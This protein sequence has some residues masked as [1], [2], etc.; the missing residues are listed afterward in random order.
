ML[1]RDVNQID[2]TPENGNA[3]TPFSAHFAAPNLIL[4]GDP[5]A[6]KTA[7]FRQAADA[8]GGEFLT[9]RQFLNKPVER[10]PRDRALWIDALDETRSGRGD[11]NT[12]DQVVTKLEAL[13]PVAVR[14]SCRAADWLGKSDLAAFKD[15]FDHNGGA[16][17]VVQLLPLSEVEQRHILSRNEIEDPG[18]FLAEA[19]RRGL[20]AMLTNPQTL[21]MLAKTV[22]GQCW[23]A[24]RAEL[25]EQAVT[26]LL[27]EHN[28]EHGER[29]LAGC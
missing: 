27:Q 7:L 18:A 20:N 14:L 22:R 4:L 13:R 2:P 8:S 17:I 1:D 29:G 25:F 5:G 16:P 11:Q 24:T 6:G 12:V 26:I 3:I 9:V 23:P 10:I 15:F 28:D 21:L 19:Q